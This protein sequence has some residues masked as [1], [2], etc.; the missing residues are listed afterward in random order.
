M[1]ARHV[2]N[3]QPPVSQRHK[4]VAKKSAAIGSAMRNPI[5]HR[6]QKVPVYILIR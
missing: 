3:A 6:P 2:D 5:R 1:P 4:I